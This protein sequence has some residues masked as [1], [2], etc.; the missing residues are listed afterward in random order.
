MGHRSV[1]VNTQ[2]VLKF[3]VQ[4]TRL[5]RDFIREAQ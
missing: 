5:Y 4:C 1:D 3:M 2:G